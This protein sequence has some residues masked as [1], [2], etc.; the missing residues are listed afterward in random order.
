MD[1]WAT[2]VHAYWV[3]RSSAWVHMGAGLVPGSMG[4]S[5]VLRPSGTGLDLGFTEVGLVLESEGMGLEPVSMCVQLD[6]GQP[7]LGTARV[8]VSVLVHGSW[9]G[10]STC[11]EPGFPGADLKAGAMGAGL[12]LGQA[13]SLDSW[14]SLYHWGLGVVDIGLELGSLEAS[15][16]CWAG[17]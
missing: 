16:L 3:G 10:T 9:S 8:G 13:R 6:P 7:G 1:L 15:L 12:A 5:L 11:W 17:N 4:T 2:G 14:S